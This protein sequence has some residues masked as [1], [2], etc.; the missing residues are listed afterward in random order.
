[1]RRKAAS[2]KT[3]KK[4]SY[5][6][7]YKRQPV[8]KRVYKRSGMNARQKMAWAQT[9]AALQGAM[10]RIKELESTYEDRKERKLN[11]VMEELN[12]RMDDAFFDEI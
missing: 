1:M 3:Y 12:R 9:G 8:V 11:S 4:R 7:T 6:R 5:K 10:R 2:K